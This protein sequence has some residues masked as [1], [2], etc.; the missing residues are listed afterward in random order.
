MQKV[1]IKHTHHRFRAT[2]KRLLYQVYLHIWNLE[3]Q[4]YRMQNFRSI[5]SNDTFA[6]TVISSL[7][8]V[9]ESL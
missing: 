9:K 2:F 7:I 8:K 6:E 5:D 3:K 4:I 1:S